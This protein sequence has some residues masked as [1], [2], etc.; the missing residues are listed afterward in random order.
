MSIQDDVSVLRRIPMFSNMDAA[1]LK[2]LAL[3]SQRLTFDQGQVLFRQGVDGDSAYVILDGQAEILVD[4]PNGPFRIAVL[5]RNMIVGEIAI[6]CDVPRTAT[7]QALTRLETLRIQKEQ[8]LTLVSEF[9]DFAIEV[10]RELAQRLAQVNNELVKTR[11][12][13]RELG[14]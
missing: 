7:V 14:G 5:E 10:L 3:T 8:F 4:S 1:K 9:P 12:R 6:L 11:A 13:I 2:L